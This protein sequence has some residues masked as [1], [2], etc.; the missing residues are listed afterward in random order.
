M[1]TLTHITL[2]AA[3]GDVV[4]G[5]KIGNKAMLWGAF[6]GLL[7]DLDVAANLFTNEINA[8]AFHRGLMHSLLFIFL[9]AAGLSRLTEWLYTKGHFQRKWYKLTIFYLVVFLL[10]VIMGS[11][12]Y[13]AFS[14]KSGMNL[15][16]LAITLASGIW[17][18]WLLWRRYI[19]VDW[20]MIE[21]T[22]RE[23][24]WLFWWT[25]LS[26]S[27][28][29]CFTSYGTQ[30]FQPFSDY[31]VSFN[32]ISVVDPLYTLPFT[33]CIIAAAAMAK[34]KASRKVWVW[35]GIVVSSA[36]LVFTLFHKNRADRIFQQA[37]EENGIEYK[38]FTT[39]PTLLN[40]FLWQGVAEGDSVFYQSSFTFLDKKPHIRQFNVLSKDQELLKPYEDGRTVQVLKWFTRGYYSVLHLGHQKYQ[41][42]DLRYGSTEENFTD[43]EKYVFRFILTEKNGKL[44]AKQIRAYHRVSGE[45]LEKLWQQIKGR[46][47]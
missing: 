39:S 29:D 5:K 6:G 15:Q 32:S 9:A 43:E 27:L 17:L 44:A 25:I 4:L 38:R 46:P 28:L 26:H 47:D 24:F 42:N 1:D 34:H 45:G 16:V 18:T 14:D 13:L 10:L 40:N 8:L 11:I 3:V 22:R 12:N 20:Q 31:P 23:W 19:R 21:A 41:L 2:G 35:S 33:V 37:L 7:P 36:Y 30:L